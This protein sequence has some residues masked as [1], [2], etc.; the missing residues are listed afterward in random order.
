MIGIKTALLKYLASNVYQFGLKF[1]IIDYYTEQDDYVENIYS[2]RK[3]WHK[4]SQY[5]NEPAQSGTAGSY[6][7]AMGKLPPTPPTRPRRWHRRTIIATLI[8][9]LLIIL[10]LL[11]FFPRPK[12]IVT[13]TPVSKT[14]SGPVKGSYSPRELSSPQQGTGQGFSHKPGTQAYGM[15]T[16]KNYTSFWVTISRGTIVTNVTGQQ[17]VTEK[18][19]HV[20]PDPIIPG[21]ASVSAHAVKVGKSG[22]IPAMSVNKPYSHGIS[23]LNESAFSGGVDD[24]AAASVQQ[25]DIDR[26]ANPLMA[27]LIQKALG[28][29]QSQLKPGEQLVKASP[30][31]SSP[32]VSSNPALGV[33]AT[34]FTVN[35]SLTC[36]DSAF[37]PQTVPP[38]EENKLKQEAIQQLTPGP[39][40][41]PVGTIAIKVEQ[42]TPDKNGEIDLLVTASG[43]WKYQFSADIKL[44]MA[45]HIARETVGD[46]KTWLLQQTGVAAAS[47]SVTGP[48]IDLSGHN[49]VPDD[50][51]AITING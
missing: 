20:P 42:E 50:L 12:A 43:T 6:G 34:K 10:V 22:N 16:F 5:S 4:L 51:R 37:N 25:S 17:V 31:C 41:I 29:L 35:V 40:F 38:Q 1:G 13:L 21:I 49:I 19:I 39:G 24:Q 28:D 14:L 23:V 46:A 26:V 2:V 33:S 7:P 44:K 30:P 45:K 47:I 48:I 3:G 18:T 8:A 32:A 15:L 36:S 27:K 11:F 9:I